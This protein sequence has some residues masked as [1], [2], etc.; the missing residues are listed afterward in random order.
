MEIVYKGIDP[1]TSEVY[2]KIREVMESDI[3]DKVDYIQLTRD[4]LNELVNCDVSNCS[5]VGGVYWH[6]GRQVNNVYTIILLRVD[7]E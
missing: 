2:C 1:E 4:E 7:N 3:F 5:Y 6:Y